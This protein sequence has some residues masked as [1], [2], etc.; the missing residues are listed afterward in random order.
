MQTAL[1]VAPD[2]ANVSSSPFNKK[3]VDGKDFHKEVI[4]ALG[5]DAVEPEGA[6]QEFADALQETAEETLDI[7]LAAAMAALDDA[8]SV[9]C[10]IP[11]SLPRANHSSRLSYPQTV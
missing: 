2:L 1:E 4:A 11:S 9:P 3:A 7:S 6:M 8:V 5:G 10:P